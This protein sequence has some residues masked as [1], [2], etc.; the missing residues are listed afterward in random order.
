MVK[1]DSHGFGF[2]PRIAPREASIALVVLCGAALAGLVLLASCGG[3]GGAAPPGDAVPVDL[4]LDVDYRGSWM[5]TRTTAGGA[6][7]LARFGTPTGSS[8]P[9]TVELGGA[10][11]DFSGPVVL[12][13]RSPTSFAIEVARGGGVL[14]LVGDAL[15]GGAAIGGSYSIAGGVCDGDAGTW[16]AYAQRAPVPVVVVDPTTGRYALGELRR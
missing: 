16:I 4:D 14:R 1:R 3:S 12:S 6:A 2:P 5:S 10:A 8:V 13:M 9:A 7:E 15:F 11:C